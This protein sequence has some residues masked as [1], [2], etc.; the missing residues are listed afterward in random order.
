[1]FRIQWAVGIILHVRKARAKLE[2]SDDSDA[3]D[4]VS[5]QARALGINSVATSDGA[6]AALAQGSS[7]RR[8]SRVVVAVGEV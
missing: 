6:Y 5:N 4:P 7:P 2:G 3:D 8:N 1:M